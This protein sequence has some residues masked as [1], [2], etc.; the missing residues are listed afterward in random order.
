MESGKDGKMGR[1]EVSEMGMWEIRVHVHGVAC[2]LRRA[3]LSNAASAGV[4]AGPAVDGDVQDL[5]VRIQ[6][7][8]DAVA[9]VHV[10]Y[11]AQNCHTHTQGIASNHGRSGYSD[12]PY[13]WA[14]IR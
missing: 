6:N 7:V 5:G 9:V 14:G 13:L 8:L 11:T 12:E 1:C 3:N 4:E 2:A 10:L